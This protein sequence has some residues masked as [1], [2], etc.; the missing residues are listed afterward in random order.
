MFLL[1]KKNIKTFINKKMEFRLKKFFFLFQIDENFNKFLFQFSLLFILKTCSW[2]KKK[3]MSLFF[4]R[5][6]LFYDDS[7]VCFMD[8]VEFFK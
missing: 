8:N 1:K 2:K 5:L 4:K 6:E 3:T 7:I